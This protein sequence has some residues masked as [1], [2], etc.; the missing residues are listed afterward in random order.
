METRGQGYVVSTMET[1]TGETETA[2][3]GQILRD[4][5]TRLSLTLNDVSEK[6][7]LPRSTL[8]KIEND[9][10]SLSYD[11]IVKISSA[12]N[13]DIS[14][15]FSRKPVSDISRSPQ[16]SFGR[17]EISRAG[18]GVLIHTDVYASRY[19]ASDLLRKKVVPI[20]VDAKIAKI[21]EFGELIRHGGEEFAYVIEG[22]IDFYTDL[23]APVRLRVGESVYFDSG[24]GHAYLAAADGPCRVLSICSS[25]SAEVVTEEGVSKVQHDYIRLDKE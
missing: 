9:K 16:P 18:D 17:R 8:S 12:L 11:K 1:H 25:D 15:L 3:P 24:I 7:G 10:M 2:H 19:I 23:Y 4:L 5:R 21:E 6:T 13:V 14:E 20:I 22:E